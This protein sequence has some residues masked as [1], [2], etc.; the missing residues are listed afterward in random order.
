MSHGSKCIET[1]IL[2]KEELARPKEVAAEQAERDKSYSD[3][4]AL[5]KRLEKQA[6]EKR[7]E[8]AR[9]ER[10]MA[11]KK[12]QE[13]K[14]KK[15]PKKTAR[16]TPA[17]VE[18]EKAD[19]MADSRKKRAAAADE[20]ESDSDLSGLEEDEKKFG[21]APPIKRSA[22]QRKIIETSDEEGV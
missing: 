6:A 4:E 19:T 5:D 8:E 11:K 17:S 14:G 10:E 12:K 1:L 7:K 15:K 13:V 2:T 16:K 18:P 22:K 20:A 9:I 21:K 3:L